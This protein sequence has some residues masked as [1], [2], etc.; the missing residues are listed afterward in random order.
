M[1]PDTL[2]AEGQA[3]LQ[4]QFRSGSRRW[5]WDP[6]DSN[7][8]HKKYFGAAP[9]LPRTG[10]GRARRP[11]EN[12]LAS[13]RCAAYAGAVGN[14]YIRNMRFHP[15]WQAIKIGQ[16]QGRSVDLNGSDP[17][18]TMNALRDDGSILWDASPL[19]L[20]TH[21]I[22]QTGFGQYYSP[23]L[24]EQ[25]QNN[26]ITAY[27]SV[28]DAHDY[29]DD[30]RHALYRAYHKGSGT[31][32]V[33]HAFSEF[34]TEWINPKGGIIPKD[35]KLSAGWH[36]YLFIDWCEIDGELY[37]IAQ[38]SYGEVGDKGFLYFPREVVNREFKKWGTA[39]KI[40]TGALKPEQIA[41]AKQ[42]TIAGRIQ[43]AIIECW[44]VLSEKFGR[45]A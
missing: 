25:A 10:L 6:R 36:A 24:N 15:D 17:R 4:P 21:G 2:D 12:Q 9:T 38:N 22:E 5:K 34:F 13:L 45:Y 42:Q 1:N 39:L 28:D 7:F 33:V 43:R 31:G 37:L 41:L 23:G 30:I 3:Y 14:S 29:F 40:P 18:A 8:S 11:V 44:Y 35:Y 26:R 27:L 20:E 16:K 32:P 19:H